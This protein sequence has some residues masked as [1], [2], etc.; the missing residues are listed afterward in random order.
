MK[1]KKACSLGHIS[2]GGGEIS[3]KM[4]PWHSQAN[5]YLK[6]YSSVTCRGE[7]IP[8]KFD[9]YSR[10]LELTFACEPDLNTLTACQV[11]ST[12]GSKRLKVHGVPI[13]W[14]P[15]IQVPIIHLLP[16][17]RAIL[18]RN[19]VENFPAVVGITSVDLTFSYNLV[20]ICHFLPLWCCC[21]ST[22]PF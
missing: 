3:H 14:V 1:K 16:C 5:N 20:C 12:F 19:L 17:M 2:L 10:Q 13:V 6:K 8:S 18:L 22:N 7:Q 15:I 4:Q 11:K 21:I 9:T